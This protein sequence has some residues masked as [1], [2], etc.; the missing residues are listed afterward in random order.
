MTPNEVG[1]RTEGAVLAALLQAGYPVALPFGPA[2]YDLIAEIDGELKRIQCKT[3]RLKPGGNESSLLFAVA[4]QPP[5]YPKKVYVGEID[6]FGVYLHERGQV[7]LVP[8]EVVAHC[9]REAALR[10][11]PSRNGQ[12]KGVHL[13]S[14]FLVGRSGVRAPDG[15]PVIHMGG[16]ANW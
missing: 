8:I 3:G 7:F 12:T 13:A 16:Y 6:Y 15:A 11:E 9:T 10:L 2:R 14:E 4:S 5:G 1:S